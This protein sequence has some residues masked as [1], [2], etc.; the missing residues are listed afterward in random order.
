M[1]RDVLDITGLLV[2]ANGQCFRLLC[3][4]MDFDGEGLSVAARVAKRRSHQQ[5]Y[6]QETH[7]I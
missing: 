1:A 6:V 2:E 5:R 3:E 7:S 4:V